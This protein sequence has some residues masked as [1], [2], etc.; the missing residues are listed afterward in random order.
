MPISVTKNIVIRNCKRKYEWEKESLNSLN[1]AHNKQ[2]EIWK[3]I[4]ED[5]K[6]IKG[7]RSS[8]NANFKAED[9]AKFSS[10]V[11]AKVAESIPDSKHK[12]ELFLENMKSSQISSSFFI[13]ITKTEI[14]KIIR[15][16]KNE[17][18]IDIYNLS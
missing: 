14:Q 1:R 9:L 8:T 11:G 13:P 16:L 2:R 4:N 12:S 6:V 5:L 15:S 7:D 18:T 3:I 10:E 17:T